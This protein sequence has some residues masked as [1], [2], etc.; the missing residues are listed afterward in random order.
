MKAHKPY[1]LSD[2]LGFGKYRNQTLLSVL[3]RDVKY[4]YWC[5]NNVQEFELS[6]EAL[7]FAQSI[8]ELFVAIKPNHQYKCQ[9]YADGIDILT[10]FPW[11]ERY[12]IYMRTCAEDAQI[13]PLFS[14]PAHCVVPI[15]LS[16]W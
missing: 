5:L 14:L 9:P 11:K 4:V 13:V 7:I 15:Q 10:T 1:N 16:I 12:L 6:N 8:S 3:Q 2:K